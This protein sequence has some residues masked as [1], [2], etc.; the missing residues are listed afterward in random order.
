MAKYLCHDALNRNKK[1]L[2]DVLFFE[3]ETTDNWML[4]KCRIQY[5]KDQLRFIK[6]N[7]DDEW[8]EE[9]NKAS[10]TMKLVKNGAT[11]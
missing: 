5:V 1:E 8:G 3:E 11:K 4:E 10:T 6:E 7:L 2:Q 9:I